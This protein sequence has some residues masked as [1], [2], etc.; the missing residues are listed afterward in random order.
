MSANYERAQSESKK[1]IELFRGEQSASIPQNNLRG[2]KK[3]TITEKSSF[4]KISAEDTIPEHNEVIFVEEKV[5][6]ILLPAVKNCLLAAK[7]LNCLKLEKHIF[8]G[9]DFISQLLYNSNPR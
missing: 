4:E 7:S 6:P 8:N 5:F 2:D 3:P 9:I 1:V